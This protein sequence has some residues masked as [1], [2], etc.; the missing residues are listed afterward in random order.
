MFFRSRITQSLKT[1]WARNFE[2][3]RNLNWITL[4]WPEDMPNEN[5]P[6]RYDDQ[7]SAINVF[8]HNS[9]L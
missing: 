4:D 2:L 7:S 1:K 5:T 3:A 8:R 9:G 6:T